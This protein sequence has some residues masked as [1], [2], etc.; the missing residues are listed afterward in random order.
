MYLQQGTERP[1][2]RLLESAPKKTRVPVSFYAKIDGRRV[3]AVWRRT[4]TSPIHATTDGKKALCGDEA[5]L[6]PHSTRDNGLD[7]S[8]H[9]AS[10]N[11]C[12]E[13]V[14]RAARHG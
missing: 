5:A 13:L 11:D 8:K 10:C 3:P 4:E 9:S 6:L 2:L 1:M 12:A 7:L 14:F